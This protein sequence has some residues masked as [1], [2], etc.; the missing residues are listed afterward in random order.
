MARLNAAIFPEAMAIETLCATVRE[1]GYD[2]LE[3]DRPHFYQR[4]RT[5]RTR[6]AFRE[7]IAGQGMEIHGLDCWVDVQPYERAAESLADFHRAI[8]WAADLDLKLLI[9]HDPWGS[10]NGHRS[11]SRCL[12][13][14]IALFRPVA[15]ACARR[16]LTLVFEPHPDTLSMDD[17][18]ALAFIDGVAAAADRQ[19]VGLLFDSCHYRVGQPETWLQAIGRL[20]PAIRHVHFSDSD[21][22]SY[23]LHMPFGE[24]LL[25]PQLVTTALRKAGFRGSLTADMYN[26]PMLLAGA[27]RQLPHVLDAERVLGLAPA[28]AVGAGQ[29]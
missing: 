9:S 24:G 4:L 29:P 26:Y 13:D 19:H 11:P 20:G 12:Q 21:G 14:C 23:A 28:A 3:L 25:D 1:L 6:K 18:W 10:V 27:R 22:E 15:E 2:S 8:D 7:W 5:E 17:G 16:G